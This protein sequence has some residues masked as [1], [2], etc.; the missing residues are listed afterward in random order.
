MDTKQGKLNLWNDERGYGIIRIG[1]EGFFLH[2]SNIIAGEPATGSW[3]KF[4][5]AAPYKDGKYPQAINATILATIDYSSTLAMP[6][7]A[8]KAAS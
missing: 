2:I 5:V 4:E 8:D 3:V 6:I 7:A 1:L